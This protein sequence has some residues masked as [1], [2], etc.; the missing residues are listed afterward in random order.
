MYVQSGALSLFMRV[1]PWCFVARAVNIYIY[2][3]IYISTH[4]YASW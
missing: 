3:Y 4:I 1:Y 2:I